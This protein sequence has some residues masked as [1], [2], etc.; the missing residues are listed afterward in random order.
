MS[1]RKALVG[2][3]LLTL[4]ACSRKVS[5]AIAVADSSV[6]YYTCTMHP[7]VRSQDPKGK[8]PV[9]G[10]DLVPVYKTSTSA[11]NTDSGATTNAAPAMAT[12]SVDAEGMVNIAPERMQEI[13]VTTEVVTKRS[14]TDLFALRRPR[15]ESTSRPCATS[16]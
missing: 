11:T 8:C 7:F 10:M 16:M 1:R 15:A 9:C 5:Q 2:L 6:A 4:T 14:L 12:S 3:S 13:G